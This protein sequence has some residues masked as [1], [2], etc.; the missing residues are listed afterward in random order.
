MIKVITGIVV[1]ICMH[2]ANPEGA[3]IAIGVGL[4]LSAILDD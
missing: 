3:I 2:N 1:F 4:I